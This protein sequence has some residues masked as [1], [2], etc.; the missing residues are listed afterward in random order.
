MTTPNIEEML[1]IAKQLDATKPCVK[2]II[3]HPEMK[4]F[5]SNALVRIKTKTFDRP[6]SLVGMLPGIEI[7]EDKKLP[8]DIGMCVDSEGKLV[9]ML[10][11]T[12]EEINKMKE[13]N[14]A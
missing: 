12:K 9:K 4:E 13:S 6:T 7:R 3:L 5:I 10:K 2:A 8:T 1:K 14:N 11:F